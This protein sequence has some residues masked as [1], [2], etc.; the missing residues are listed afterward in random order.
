MFEMTT[1]GAYLPVGGMRERIVREF[2]MDVY[3][4][5][6][7]KWITNKDLL[8]S[9]WNSAQCYVAAMIE[10]LVGRGAMDTC[11][12]MTECLCCSPKT[13]QHC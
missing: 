12:C 8:Y 4:L 10:E 6:Y 7:F 13:S 1:V 3:T 11:I 5:L 9:M 2:E